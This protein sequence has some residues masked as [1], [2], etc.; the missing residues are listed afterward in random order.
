MPIEKKSLAG[1]KP[2]AS[3]S[4]KKKSNAKVDTAKP[5]SSKVVAAMMRPPF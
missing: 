4:N 5:A 3:P 2:S 1:K